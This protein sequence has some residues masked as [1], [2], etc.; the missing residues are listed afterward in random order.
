MDKS[1]FSFLS[2]LLATPS[3]TGTE[4]RAAK[5]VKD[6]LK[7]HVDEI[8]TD[9]HGN[10]FFVINPNGSPRVMLAAHI[11]Q[12]GF[13]V[14][15]VTDKGFL[16]LVAVGGVDLAVVPG[17]RIIIHSKN[18][19]VT[20]VIG[21]KAIH[22]MKPEERDG[23][24]KIELSDLHVD[25]GATSEQE[26]LDKVQI[27]DPVTFPLGLAEL[28]DDLITAHA[29]D[30]RVGVWVMAEALRI[31]ASDK[32][33]RD[34]LQ[35]AVFGV[36]T[37][38]EEIGLRGAS[39]ASFSVDP[40]IGIAIDVAHAIDTPNSEEKAHG[41]IKMAKGPTLSYGPNI[42]APL[43]TL[44]E[45]VAA[46]NNIPFQRHAAP[47]ATGTDA[48]TMQISRGGVATALIG[49]PC[50]YM[51]TPVEVVSRIDLTHAA[52]LLAQTLLTITPDTNLIPQ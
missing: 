11:D 25:I 24:K 42:N 52:N 17:S 7:P 48:N 3:V 49:L 5:V 6:F 14:N 8:R 28:G 41:N 26:A 12:I 23:A 19:P 34:K 45:S 10:T 4:Q 32:T 21:R 18:G 22:L 40:Q 36:A 33:K 29:L 44:F 20:G 16:Y 9:V 47:R 50:R 31:L 27:G 39:T 37:V 46:S 35:P 30:D 43:N 15:H 51:H 38:Q 1:S 2:T 13:L